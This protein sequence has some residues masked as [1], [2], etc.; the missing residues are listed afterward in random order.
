MT[1]QALVESQKR[2]NSP[3]KD[4]WPLFKPAGFMRT[5]KWLQQDPIS[6]YSALYRECGDKAR[7]RLLPGLNFFVV[8]DPAVFEHILVSHHRKYRKP[9]VLIQPV[10]MLMGDGLFSSDGQTWLRQRRLMQPAF[11]KSALTQASLAMGSVIGDF[12]NE[13]RSRVGQPFDLVPEMMRLA[14]RIAGRTMFGQESIA[15]ASE[16]GEAYRFLFSEIGARMNRRFRWPAWVPSPLNQRI[17]RSK[18]T[19]D[20]LVTAIIADRRKGPRAGDLLDLLLD[21]RDE[22]TNEQMTDSQIRDEVLTLL[23]AGHE[24]VGAALSWS[25]YLLGQD[26]AAAR[27]LH[28]EAASRLGGRAP[29]AE[30]APHLPF[31]RAVFEEAMRLY[32]PAWGVPRESIE[33]DEIDGQLIPRKSIFTLLSW[34]T[35]RDPKYWES[36]VA[37]RPERFLSSPI[38]NRPKHAYMPFGAGPRVCIGNNFALLEGSLALAGIAQHYKIALE[39]GQKIEPDATFTLRPKPGLEVRI[40]PWR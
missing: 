16:I 12:A 29:T 18:S 3:R 39:P 33:P 13:W 19:I 40:E 6:F 20:R 35:H 9:R 4:A 26:P 5:V 1:K 22:E 11:S 30:D 38:G 31:T 28:E 15:A 27:R 8:S 21:A 14:L 25:W 10:R 24:T 37:F 36:P 17:K 34:Q 2:S 32:P 7:V 23:T